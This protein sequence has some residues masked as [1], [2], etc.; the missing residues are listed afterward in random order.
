MNTRIAL[1]VALLPLAAARLASGAEPEIKTG[2][3][4]EVSI[5]TYLKDSEPAGAVPGRSEIRV[6]PHVKLKH[7]V[8]GAFMQIQALHDF[9]NS[10]RSLIRLKDAYVQLRWGGL[11]VRA[12]NQVLR[13]GRMDMRPALDLLTPKDYD[14]LWAPEHIGAPALL[15]QYGTPSFSAK[16]AW[17]PFFRP[18]QYSTSSSHRWNVLL[19][20]PTVGVAGSESFPIHYLEYRDPQTPDGAGLLDSQLG[21]RMELFLPA[22]DLG[23]QGY[24]GRDLLPTYHEFEGL[25]GDVMEPTAQDLITFLDQGVDV[26][27]TPMFAHKGVVGG[28][29]ALVLGPVVVKGELAYTITTDPDHEFC[30]VPDPYLQGTIG[31]E[32][33]ANDII[34]DQDLQLRFEVAGDH[35]LP[36]DDVINRDAHCGVPETQTPIRDVNHISVLSFYGNVQWTF[37][38]GLT[39]DVRGFAAIEGDYLVRVELSTT[40]RGM[41]RL[42]LAGLITDGRDGSFMSYYDRN[43]RMEFTS[44][45]LF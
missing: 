40:L 45:F 7:G 16:V 35:E 14:E 17:L 31:A 18:G 26:A 37:V 1:L 5:H 36:A 34:G 33:I 10:E 15:L 23:L 39:L 30:D 6:E 22:L 9:E 24:Y 4:A 38:E 8:F 25:N 19:S 20:Q 3:D 27:L 11:R 43:D 41:V 32:W 44:T 2:G 28:D 12:G 29:M 13:W 21:L 42:G